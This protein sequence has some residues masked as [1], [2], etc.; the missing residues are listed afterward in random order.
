MKIKLEEF[1]KVGS[2]HYL[3]AVIIRDTDTWDYQQ[4][5]YDEKTQ[6]FSKE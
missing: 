3:D 5:V 1:W 4:F 2:R 6:R